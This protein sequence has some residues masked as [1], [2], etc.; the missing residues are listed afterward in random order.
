MKP[1]IER[2]EEKFQ[3][4]PNSG[5]WIWTAGCFG[6]S[7]KSTGEKYGIF[8]LNG[9]PTQAHR[10]SYEFYIGDPKCIFVCHSCDNYSCVNPAHLF[11]GTNSSNHIDAS[12]K[13]R[14]FKKLT[15]ED[16]LKIIDRRLSG[17]SL[18]SI[19]KDFGCTW[20][21]IQLSMKRWKRFGL[22]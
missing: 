14:L 9:K 2:F 13:G 22:Y 21:N 1:I 6:T 12:L 11:A 4:E 19:A 15:C 16:R 3:P 7:K 10:V 8:N 18:K 17:E 20:V 5:C